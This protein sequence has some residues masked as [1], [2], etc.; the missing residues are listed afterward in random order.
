[1]NLKTARGYETPV[2]LAGDYQ[3]PVPGSDNVYH[4]IGAGATRSAVF[5]TA[6]EYE[7]IADVE[8]SNSYKDL[9]KTCRHPAHDQ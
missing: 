4:D 7:I 8:C 2:L 9:T 6:V 5:Q 1:M 3:T